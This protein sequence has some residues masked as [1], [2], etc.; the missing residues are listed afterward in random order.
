MAQK[1]EVRHADKVSCPKGLGALLVAMHEDVLDHL[2]KEEQVLFPMI[3]AG[4]GASAVGP[5]H[6]MEREHDEHGRNLR[7][8][9]E[10]TG[11]LQP[12]AE[13]CVTWRALY[14]GLQQFEEELMAHI[15]LENNILF[16]RALVA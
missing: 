6:V 9:R 1:V 15:H 2:E 8:V 11:D 14:L 12:P 16:R 7:R 10:L 4:Q 13:A 5:V 3:L